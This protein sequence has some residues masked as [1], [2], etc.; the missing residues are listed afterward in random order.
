MDISLTGS[1]SA[2][3]KRG[4]VKEQYQNLLVNFDII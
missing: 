3:E 2:Y 1:T 4:G